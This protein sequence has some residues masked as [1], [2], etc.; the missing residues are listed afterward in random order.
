MAPQTGSSCGA[1]F[2]GCG[3]RPSTGY[4][5]A[6]SVPQR[7][8]CLVRQWKLHHRLDASA[9]AQ[10]LLRPRHPRPSFH[11]TRWIGFEVLP[12]LG[13]P[14]HWDFSGFRKAPIARVCGSSARRKNA[15]ARPSAGRPL[16]Q[17]RWPANISRTWCV[18]WLRLADMRFAILGEWMTNRQENHRSGRCATLPGSDRQTSLLE[19]W[20][21][22]D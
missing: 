5:F 21:G 12:R 9:R 7:R 14:V 11:T 15:L 19:M 16:G 10:G 8:F 20:S 3:A 1:A 18:A 13:I 22:F 4:R 6:M 2:N 17:Q